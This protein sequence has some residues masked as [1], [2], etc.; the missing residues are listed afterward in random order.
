M[1]EER[2]IFTREERNR[3]SERLA[4]IR[5]QRRNSSRLHLV[6]AAV[7]VLIIAFELY[8]V[9]LKIS[10]RTMPDRISSTNEKAAEL[11]AENE[12]AQ[13]AADEKGDPEQRQELK[14]SWESLKTKLHNAEY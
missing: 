3:H 14:E 7:L 10:N 2:S 6:I 1:D 4:K 9:S 11:E 13:A 5:A 8:F 12:T